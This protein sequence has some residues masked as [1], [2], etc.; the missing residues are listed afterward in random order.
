MLKLILGILFLIAAIAW[1]LFGSF[2]AGM[3]SSPQAS[4][5]AWP[6]IIWPTGTLMV[7]AAIFFAAWKN[8]W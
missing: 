8:E 5:E 3:S 6:L 7:I 1:F 2:A 4:A